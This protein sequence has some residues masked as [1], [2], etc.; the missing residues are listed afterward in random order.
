LRSSRLRRWKAETVVAAAAP[1]RPA[2][3]LAAAA[4]VLGAADGRHVR[5]CSARARRRPRVRVTFSQKSFRRPGIYQRA[6]RPRRSHD[7]LQRRELSNEAEV[8]VIRPEYQ[9]AV[10]LGVAASHLL[11]VSSKNELA[12][13][14]KARW[15]HHAS[16]KERWLVFRSEAARRASCSKSP[17][18]RL[19]A[20]RVAACDHP[21]GAGQGSARIPHREGPVRGLGLL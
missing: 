14:T 2:W 8:F 12:I 9:E 11:A 4:V 20:G 16:S 21:R 17:G 3:M 19:V 6:I 1:K 10:P 5:R 18:G 15:L 13:L 7:R